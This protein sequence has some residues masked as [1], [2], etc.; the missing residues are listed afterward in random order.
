[1][2]VTVTFI[3]ALGIAVIRQNAWGKDGKIDGREDEKGCI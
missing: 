2:L 1:M 3:S